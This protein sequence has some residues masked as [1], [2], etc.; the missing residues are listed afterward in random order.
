LKKNGYN[1]KPDVR[2]Q[3]SDVRCQISD[4]KEQKRGGASRPIDGGKLFSPYVPAATRRRRGESR[5]VGTNNNLTKKVCKKSVQNH[6]KQPP[7]TNP[8]PR[9]KPALSEVERAQS[10]VLSNH[11]WSI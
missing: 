4:E 7:T 1:T 3:T 2:R 10:N 5:R 6:P 9:T 11:V 8:D